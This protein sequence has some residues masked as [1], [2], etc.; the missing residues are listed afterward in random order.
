MYLYPSK[1]PYQ[2]LTKIVVKTSLSRPT[3]R[4]STFYWKNIKFLIRYKLLHTYNINLRFFYTTII[5]S[6]IFKF[7]CNFHEPRPLN[8]FWKFLISKN[9]EDLC[10]HS[11]VQNFPINSHGCL[12]FLPLSLKMSEMRTVMNLVLIFLN[13]ALP[14]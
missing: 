13:I 2:I 6:R 5:L 11:G 9:L 8:F 10:E 1:Y 14:S 7:S 4:S 12:T 3:I